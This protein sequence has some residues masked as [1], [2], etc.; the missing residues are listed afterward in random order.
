MKI[1]ISNDD[2]ILANGIR[3]LIEALAPEHDV[4]VVAPDRERSA[5][6]HSLTLHTPLRVE[7]VDPKYGAKRCWMTTGTPGDCVKLAINAILAEDEKPDLVISGINHG[8]NL[9]ADILYSG[10]VSCAMEGAMMG[11]PSIATSLASM[12]TEY[13]DFK[14]TA[15]IIAELIK[16]LDTYKIPPKT[17]LNIN[18]PGLEL[19]DISGIAVTELGS[20]MF[21]DEYE[22]RVDPRGKVYYWMAGEL[23][24]EAD[25][26]A[27]DISAVRNNMI[28]V[29]PITYEMTRL[30]IMKELQ[31]IKKV[32]DPTEI[33]LVVDAML[34]QDA[35]NVAESFNEMLDISGVVLTKLDGDT[36]GGAALSVRYVTGKPIKFVGTGEKLDTIEPFYP[37]RMASRILGMG[38][39]LSL[40]EKA[41]EAYDKKQAEALEKKMRENSFTLADY[42]D[43]MAQLK[44]MGSLES[45]M[46]MVPGMSGKDVK[47]DEDMLVRTEAIILSMT[48]KERD[49]PDIINSSRKKRIAKGS[50]TS[51]EEINR[52][53]KQFE[54]MKKL[55]KQMS[56]GK[57]KGFGGIGRKGMKMPF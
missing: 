53:L 3:A 34:G 23:I 7:E 41:E 12:R 27:T 17:I 20:R 21:T 37:D 8:P 57:F 35:V 48:K 55:M 4:Y 2:G 46:A 9:G 14:L 13:E 54:Q 28:S 25:D 31:D 36:R 44:K 43:Q 47:I 26:V 19:D 22:K 11:Y 6:G 39:V 29:T 1:L 15:R 49:N 32:T 10:T 33:L 52:L 5:A 56:S 38:D 24:T 40:I 45:V 18:V 51:V 16:K 42:L 30:N 50:G